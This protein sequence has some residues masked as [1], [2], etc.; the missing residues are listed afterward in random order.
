M[1]A[2]LLYGPLDVLNLLT[3][4]TTIAAVFATA[5]SGAV[6]RRFLGLSARLMDGGLWN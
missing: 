5:E 3:D 4:L 1:G 2:M 6:P